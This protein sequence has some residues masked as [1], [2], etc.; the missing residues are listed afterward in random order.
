MKAPTWKSEPTAIGWS[1][2]TV[3]VAETLAA[4]SGL[5]VGRTQ[6]TIMV[7]KDETGTVVLPV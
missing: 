4:R 5:S 7:F 3:T 2:V 1:E 6:V